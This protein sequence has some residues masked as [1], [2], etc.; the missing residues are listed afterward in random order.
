MLRKFGFYTLLSSPLVLVIVGVFI[1]LIFALSYKS[2]KSFI[3]KQ[4][5]NE[6]VCNDYN[7]WS[8][9]VKGYS[10]SNGKNNYY[11]VYLSTK[12]GDVL[13]KKIDRKSI[14]NV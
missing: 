12:N 4:N 10:C 3:L 6:Y 1:V 14:T 5:N 7:R 9:E 2:S 11:R 8:G 13:V